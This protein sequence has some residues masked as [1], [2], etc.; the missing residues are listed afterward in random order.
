MPRVVIFSSQC[1]WNIVVESVGRSYTRSTDIHA[2]TPALE[3]VHKR[4]KSLF[5]RFRSAVA[6]STNLDCHAQ[7]AD[8][9]EI[10]DAADSVYL[11]LEVLRFCRFLNLI[12]VECRT[13]RI[14]HGMYMEGEP[15]VGIAHELSAACES[16][17]PSMP[18]LRKA[19]TS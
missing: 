7:F 13:A 10:R 5:K 14:L 16:R 12:R 11:S 6:L 3:V 1:A 2:R 9:F 19:R 15:E 8:M 17:L 4:Y 18:R